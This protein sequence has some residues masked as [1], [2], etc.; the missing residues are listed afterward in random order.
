MLFMDRRVFLI[1]RQKEISKVFLPL[2]EEL[3]GVVVKY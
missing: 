2:V 1:S 3:F